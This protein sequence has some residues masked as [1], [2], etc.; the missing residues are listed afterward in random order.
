MYMFLILQDN[1]KATISLQYVLAFNSVLGL[2]ESYKPTH[3]VSK[4]KHDTA[5]YQL[6]E[7]P[8]G[9]GSTQRIVRLH[10]SKI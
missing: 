7:D 6:V 3:S 5:V 4:G 9:E 2:T 8:E 10:I 1:Y